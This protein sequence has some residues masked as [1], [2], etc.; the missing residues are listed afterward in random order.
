[1]AVYIQQPKYADVSITYQDNKASGQITKSNN[2]NTVLFNISDV[3]PNPFLPKLMI[4]STGNVQ[5]I[6]KGDSALFFMHFYDSAKGQDDRKYITGRG[7]GKN[8]RGILAAEKQ[9]TPTTTSGK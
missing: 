8:W 5:D 3:T 9:D 6:L 2:T 7:A 4:T 1:M